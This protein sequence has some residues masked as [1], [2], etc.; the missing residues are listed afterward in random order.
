[1]QLLLPRFFF[2]SFVTVSPCAELSHCDLSDN[3]AAQ[4]SEVSEGKENMNKLHYQGDLS[5]FSTP[6]ISVIELWWP[7]TTGV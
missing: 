2:H 4:G 7:S 1:M 3:V 5:S 6:S